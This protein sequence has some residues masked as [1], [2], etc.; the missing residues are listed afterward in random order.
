[1]SWRTGLTNIG[2]LV[3]QTNI[4]EYVEQLDEVLQLFQGFRMIVS[5][6]G[7]PDLK[8]SLK[9]GRVAP[10]TQSAVD[11]FSKYYKSVL[12][13]FPQSCICLKQEK[14]IVFNVLLTLSN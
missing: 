8:V 12:S 14:S 6:S 9:D 4:Q 5:V 1:M 7:H 3:M 10:L 2:I 11:C 13:C